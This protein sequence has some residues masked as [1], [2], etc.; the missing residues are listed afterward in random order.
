MGMG[1][2]QIL[3]LFLLAPTLNGCQV[4][5]GNTTEDPDV[6]ASATPSPSPTEKRL[7]EV[8]LT[9]NGVRLGTSE[10]EVLELLGKPNKIEKGGLDDCS[11]GH[12]R[13]FQY[14]GLMIRLLSDGI[15]RNY[16]VTHIRVTSEKW[17]IAP[18][19]RIGDPIF[20]VRET[21]GVPAHEGPA[22]LFF[23]GA[24]DKDGWVHFFGEDERLIRVVADL[25]LC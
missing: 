8:D 2:R 20:K 25:T 15:G 14:H 11:S 5:G 6:T 19:I 17:E 10:S 7:T 21:F 4:G 16:T 23:Y 12:L 24:K 22:G 3:L 18:G 9:I 13:E 1:Y